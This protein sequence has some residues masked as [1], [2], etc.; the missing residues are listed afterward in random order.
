MVAGKATFKAVLF[1]FAIGAGAFALAFAVRYLSGGWFQSHYPYLTFFCAVIVT[2]Y[3]GGLWPALT[4][5]ALAAVATYLTYA[6]PSSS[7]LNMAD[8]RMGAAVFF[9]TAALCAM[10][11]ASLRGARDHLE[12]ERQRYADLAENRDLLYR[13]LQHRVSNNIQTVAGLLRVQA[14]AA[15]PSPRKALTEAADRI[16]L[17]ARIQRDLHDHA[18]APTPFCDFARDLL[19][20]AVSAAGAE[21]IGVEINGGG[22]PLHPDQATPVCLVLLECVNNALEHAF[23]DERAGAIRV[24]L[25]REGALWRLAISDD[26]SG[27]PPDLD[28]PSGS[29]LGL[30]IV[31]AM[32]TQLQGE[33]S[34]RDGAPGALCILTY[35][36]LK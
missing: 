29:S 10:L 30:K 17:L 13:E 22:E 24:E 1:G 2:A 23:G 8:A 28:I 15:S 27:P 25:A 34:I 20:R 21:Q 14:S 7:M 12:L 26:G 36:A 5:D 16:G 35:P 9:G 6:P 4:V 31:R 18:G 3:L 11:I 19:S 33:F 32:A